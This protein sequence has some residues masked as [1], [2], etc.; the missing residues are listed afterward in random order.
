MSSSNLDGPGDYH[1]KWSK[2]E[3]KDKYRMISLMCGIFKSDINEH[4][5][6]TEIDL[7]T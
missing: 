2:S 7:Q 6:K 4:I 1:T 5:Y 3:E